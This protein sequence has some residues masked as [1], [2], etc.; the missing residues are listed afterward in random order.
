MVIINS[1]ENTVNVS[2]AQLAPNLQHIQDSLGL[3]SSDIY[4][5]V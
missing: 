4:Y 5:Q 3:S 1:N 2:L